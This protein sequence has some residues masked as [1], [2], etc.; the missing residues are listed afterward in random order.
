MGP[1]KEYSHSQAV[2]RAM[3]LD[4]LELSLDPRKMIIFGYDFKQSFMSSG[5]RGFLILVVLSAMSMIFSA[6]LSFPW[7]QIEFKILKNS[8]FRLQ[9]LQCESDDLKP[10]PISRLLKGR[11]LT[12]TLT[13]LILYDSIFLQYLSLSFYFWLETKRR[14]DASG[15]G[16]VIQMVAFTQGT[17]FSL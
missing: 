2:R 10:V 13:E 4:G 9:I 6:P 16:G 5:H 15:I 3:K 11:T 17:N 12:A 8:I 14:D 1:L 7:F